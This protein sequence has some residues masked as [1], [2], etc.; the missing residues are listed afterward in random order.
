MK[1]NSYIYSLDVAKEFPT[2][3]TLL[4]NAEG[5]VSFWGKRV[6][7]VAGYEGSFSLDEFVIIILHAARQRSESDVLTAQE[8]VAGREIAHKLRNFYQVT[9]TK[10][11][12][13]NWFTR[14]LNFIREYRLLSYYPRVYV[15]TH[16]L[17]CA[18][19]IYDYFEER[20]SPR[21]VL[22]PEKAV[23]EPGVYEEQRKMAQKKVSKAI[24]TIG[25]HRESCSR[26]TERVTGGATV[27]PEVYSLG[28]DIDLDPFFDEMGQNR[29]N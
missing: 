20:C 25:T 21:T 29:K 14:L 4:R 17:T 5:N 16:Y 10:I 24:G 2:I 9:D 23:L 28:S 26:H 11:S 19:H 12:Q 18:G 13:A 22:V 6:I 7:T 8:K 3:N 15:E 1:I 27:D